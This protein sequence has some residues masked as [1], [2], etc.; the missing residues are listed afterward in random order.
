MN[1]V[2]ALKYSLIILATCV[3]TLTCRAVPSLQFKVSENH[4]Y[5]V[6]SHG[7]PFFYPGD[8]AWELFHRLNRE[9]AIRYLDDRAQ[10]GFTVI[11]AVALAE[12]DGLNAPNACG[13]KPLLNNNPTTPEVR[14]GPDNDY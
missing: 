4:R 7:L 10:K 5:L 6:D 9:D 12:F 8:T 14:D 1:V 11:Q 13:Y 3:G 2:K